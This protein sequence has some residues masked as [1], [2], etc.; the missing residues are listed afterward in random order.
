MRHRF[1]RNLLGEILT[2]SRMIK[3]A[4][5]I[6]FIVLLFDA[7]IFYYSWTNQEKTILIASG[8][9]LFL[10]ILEIFAVIKE[11]HEHVSKIKRQEVLEQR[12]R[13]ITEGIENPTVR[14]IV[15]EFMTKY[16]K[17]YNIR[18]VYHIACSLMD[19]L[20]KK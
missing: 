14:K 1:A 20:K 2:A 4:L 11:I 19:E 3:I 17:E 8:F 9:V 6:P 15:D 16:P 18:E 10:S 7:E 13:K 5:L 12:L